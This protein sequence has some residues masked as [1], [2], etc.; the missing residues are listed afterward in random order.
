MKL[1]TIL[2]LLIIGQCLLSPSFVEAL[3]RCKNRR[4]FNENVKSLNERHYCREYDQYCFSAVCR[5]TRAKIRPADVQFSVGEGDK[6]ETLSAHKLILLAASDVFEKMFLFDAKNAKAVTA[7]G[8]APLEEI[9]PIEVPDVEVGAFKAMLSFIYADDLSGISEDNVFDVLF[10]ADKYNVP[11]LIKACVNFPKGKLRNIFHSIELARKLGKALPP[12]QDIARNCLDYIDKNAANLIQT[13]EFLQIDQKLLRFWAVI[14][15]KKN[16]QF[17]MPHFVGR[18]KNAVKMGKSDFSANIVRSGVLTSDQMMSV[19]QYYSHPDADQPEPY[20]LQFP[21]KRRTSS[22]PYK[23][24]GKIVLKI[25]KVS[26]FVHVDSRRL[27]EAVYIRGLPWKILVTSAAYYDR[28]SF[29]LRCNDANTDSN[30][31]CA[32][33]ATIRIVS[34]K[35]GKEDHTQELSRSIF[36]LSAKGWGMQYFMP[37]EKL[38]DPQ[39]GWYDAKNDTV[40]LSAEV[41]AE[42]PV[43]VE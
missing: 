10:A 26:E 28:F 6:K 20:S 43:G 34:Q 18:T 14:S 3:L 38:M 22:D 13:E 25:D 32:G 24:K 27:S 29:Y 42:V 39:N 2:I 5:T 16:F 30:W 15:S 40:I 23:A 17:G 21:T 7:G 31:S 1:R 36:N 41:T 12:C 35:E 11:G 4:G 8:K 37:F 9:K 33:S 19:F